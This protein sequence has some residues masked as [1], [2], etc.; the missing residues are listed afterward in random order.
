MQTALILAD[1][2]LKIPIQT[3]HGQTGRQFSLDRSLYLRAI[4]KVSHTQIMSREQAEAEI[5]K[6]TSQNCSLPVP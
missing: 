3:V 1:I 6:I 5:Q 4:Y 2:G